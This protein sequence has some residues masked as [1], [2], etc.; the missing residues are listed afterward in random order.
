ML[1]DRLFR[2]CLLFLFGVALSAASLDR[3]T[4]EQPVTVQMR[5][6]R[7]LTAQI[8]ARTDASRLWLRFSSAST[9]VLRPIAWDR[10]AGARHGEK[11]MTA[12]EFRAAIDQ[13]KTTHKD[14]QGD[15]SA[16]RDDRQSP[17]SHAQRAREVL[18]GDRRVRSVHIDARVANWD[19]DVESDGLLVHVY[20]LDE[21]GQLVAARG[22]ATVTLLGVAGETRPSAQGGA[23]SNR[24]SFPKLGRWTRQIRV[25]DV[26]PTGV[27]LK[28]PFGAVHPEFD[29]RPRS[30]GSVHVR[31]TAPGHG[32]FE[33]TAATVRIRSLDWT[34]EVN[35]EVR[36]SRFF[37]IERTGRTR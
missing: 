17:D 21:A 20:P 35:N 5:S 36:G 26:G 2:L 33:D 12:A 25:A 4:A 30:L 18:G 8:D 28:L 11:V 37:P 1:I 23:R 13:L 9:V 31:L 19:A 32:V 22:S 7:S 6:G 24:L 3:A 34:R 27:V 15:N 16:P 29:G 10:V 14:Q